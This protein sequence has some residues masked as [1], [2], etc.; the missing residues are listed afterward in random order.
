[1]RSELFFKNHFLPFVELRFSR[2]S[3]ASFKPHMHQTLGIGA[4][5]RGEVLYNVSGKKAI[6]APGSLVVIN[7]ETLHTCNPANEAC[8]S[9]YMLQLDTDWCFQV[10]RSM[11]EIKHFIGVEKTRIDN[12]PLY[13]QYCKTIEH[14]MDEKIH[15]QEK[16]QI[17]FDLVCV[18]F[19][20]ACSPQAKKKELTDKIEELKQ[21]LSADLRKDYT[22]NSLAEELN[23]NP[24]TL[25]RS[26]KAVTG[27]TPHA[28]RMNCRIEQARAL[29]QQGRDIVET[30]LECGF[31][32]QS[33]FHRHFKAMTTVTPQ[34]YR[35]NF[36]Q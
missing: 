23:F 6:L 22:L 26:F 9:Y 14:L 12:A 17:L 15:L 24:Y 5:Q 29:L 7:P 10:Q 28:Y 4:V 8:R 2:S 30:A 32:D 20:V 3:T 36:I 27:I 33:H 1:M 31:F 35:V 11:W 34:E 13:E 18:V 16:E 21:I 25:I 19:S